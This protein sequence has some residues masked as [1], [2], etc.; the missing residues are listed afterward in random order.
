MKRYHSFLKE[1]GPEVGTINFL[2]G[3]EGKD[4]F[5]FKDPDEN[6]LSAC[7]VTHQGQVY[8]AGL[9]L[10][11]FSWEDFSHGNNDY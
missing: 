7:N 10:A 5:G 2:P 3:M 8:R 11:L 6:L 1:Q 9:C 4:G